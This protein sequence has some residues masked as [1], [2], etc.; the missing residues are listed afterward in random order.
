M[1]RKKDIFED[2][3]IAR[4]PYFYS[5]YHPSWFLFLFISVA[6]CGIVL[7]GLEVWD[8]FNASH[9]LLHDHL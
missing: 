3:S 4:V 1:G 8:F 7:H 2:I 5:K 9:F 6:V